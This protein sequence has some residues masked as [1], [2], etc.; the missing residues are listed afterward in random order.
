MPEGG[1]L[2]RFDALGKLGGL[3]VGAVRTEGLCGGVGFGGAD[4]SVGGV[5]AGEQAGEEASEAQRSY[6]KEVAFGT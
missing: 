1:D 2:G 6:L 5:A 4:G 3:C